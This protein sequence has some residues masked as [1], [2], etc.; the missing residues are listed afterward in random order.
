MKYLYGIIGIIILGFITQYFFTWWSIAFVAFLIGA[1]MKLN[2]LQSYLVGFLGVFL[3]WGAYAAFLNNANDG[4]MAGKIGGLF[5]N[6]GPFQMVLVTAV[7]GGIIGG[8]G[9]L[10]GSLGRNLLKS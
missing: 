6:L 5:G 10:T 2:N 7:L 9:A 3:I 4:I 1:L 8:F